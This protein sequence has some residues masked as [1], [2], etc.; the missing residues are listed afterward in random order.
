MNQLTNLTSQPVLSDHDREAQDLTRIL[1]AS[2]KV[3][4]E[5]STPDI[6]VPMREISLTDTPLGLSNGEARDQ[7][8]SEKIRQC[9][10]MILPARIPIPT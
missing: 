1:P 8:Q 7:N 3:Y 2:R 10:F 4:I 5:G 6:R 9:W